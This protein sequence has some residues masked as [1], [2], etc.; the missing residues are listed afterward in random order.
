MF[1]CLMHWLRCNNVSY[2]HAQTLRA[3][4]RECTDN[5][6]TGA[7]KVLNVFVVGSHVFVIT[8]IADDV[9][10]KHKLK[11]LAAVIMKRLCSILSG[12]CI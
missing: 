8:G 2:S 12:V 3:I 6:T 5:E 10:C 11:F 7:H 9:S 1:Y 4:F